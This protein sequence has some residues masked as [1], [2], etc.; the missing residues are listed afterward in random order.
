MQAVN[1][2][3]TL[4]T[5]YFTKCLST[6]S[7]IDVGQIQPEGY[8]RLERV[9]DLCG[10]EPR[11]DCTVAMTVHLIPSSFLYLILLQDTTVHYLYCY[12]DQCIHPQISWHLLACRPT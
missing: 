12:T 3:V 10:E 6:S 1:I 2:E 8:A 7:C 5:R 11:R 4:Q 9:S